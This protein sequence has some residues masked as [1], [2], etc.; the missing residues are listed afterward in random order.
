MRSRLCPDAAWGPATDLPRRLRLDP[1]PAGLSL[2]AR[3]AARKPVRS[4][5]PPG[6]G[7]RL[8]P[9]SHGAGENTPDA[10]PLLLTGRLA[11]LP[12]PAASRPR[13]SL[14]PMPRKSRSSDRRPV[15]TL[16]T[17]HGPPGRADRCGLR[18]VETWGRST[19]GFGRGSLPGPPRRVELQ[20]PLAS[21]RTS[22][23][24]AAGS[25]TA[26]QV[27]AGEGRV[28]SCGPAGLHIMVHRAR[29]EPVSRR[30]G[31]VAEGHV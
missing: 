5:C 13:P 14:A 7:G 16:G 8:G 20:H 28:A 15:W 21:C 4:R 3:P 2:Y 10:S 1:T 30:D 25:T 6:Y 19:T 17:A 18:D 22:L 26:F 11:L 23:L 29:R 9:G 27:P 24:H 31:T 12:W